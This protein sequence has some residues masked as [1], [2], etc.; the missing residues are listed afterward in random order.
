MSRLRLGA[1]LLGCIRG[2]L[3]VGQQHVRAG[4]L[5]GYQRPRLLQDRPWQPQA[6]CDGQRVA[7]PGQANAQP[8]GRRE[9]LYVELDAGVLHQRRAKGVHLEL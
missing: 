9:R 5:G 6:L 1:L 7:A 2:C 4:I 3:D 8:K